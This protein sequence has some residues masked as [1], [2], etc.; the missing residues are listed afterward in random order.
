MTLELMTLEK[1]MAFTPNIMEY[2]LRTW[3]KKEQ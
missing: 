1:A 3:R 2:A